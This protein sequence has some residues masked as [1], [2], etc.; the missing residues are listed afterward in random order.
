MR[1]SSSRVDNPTIS[2]TI[3]T[4]NSGTTIAVRSIT[5]IAL[6]KVTATTA[7]TST[8]VVVTASLARISYVMRRLS[9]AKS[10]ASSVKL[11]SRWARSSTLSRR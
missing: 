10:M 6:M 2:E 1:A 8:P 9:N 11:C 3:A 7:A 5:A 4:T